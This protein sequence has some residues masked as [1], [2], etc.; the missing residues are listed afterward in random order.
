MTT[1]DPRPT[2][3]ILF[4]PCLSQ[5]PG[6]TENHHPQGTRD[7]CLSPVPLPYGGTDRIEPSHQSVPRLSRTTTKTVIR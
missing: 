1:P 2:T 7:S 6:Q 3:P 5:T 4:V